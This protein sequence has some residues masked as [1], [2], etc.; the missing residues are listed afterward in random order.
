MSDIYIFSPQNT[1]LV[2][3]VGSWRNVTSSSKEIRSASWL[4][5]NK[6]YLH[7]KWASKEGW[8]GACWGGQRMTSDDPPCLMDPTSSRWMQTADRSLPEQITGLQEMEK[9]RSL[10]L[11]LTGLRGLDPLNASKKTFWTRMLERHQVLW[12]KTNSKDEKPSL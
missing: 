10:F 1:L 8:E 4:W 9:G 7:L 2:S 6:P 11:S 5:P 3:G 12:Y